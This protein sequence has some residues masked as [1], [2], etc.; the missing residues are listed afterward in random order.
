MLFDLDGTLVDP[1][2]GISGG[3]A[4]ALHEMGLP[5]PGESVLAA[6]V[7]PKLSDALLDLTDAAAVQLPEL[8]R[9]YRRW[10]ALKG[11]AMGR[12]YPGVREVLKDLQDRGIALGVATQKPQALAG[13]VL[14]AHGLAGYFSEVFGSADDET[15]RPSDPGYR[16]GKSEII[17]SAA[18]A[19][20]GPGQP[21]MVGDRAQDVLGA[22]A[23]GL[24]CI[25]VKWGFSLRGELE[26]AGAA[27]IVVD[28]P[29]LL[30]ELNRRL[31]R[32]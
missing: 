15:L 3:I 28:A 17:A 7:G 5:V 31:A 11:I 22:R 20:S 13:T 8:I 24:D 18:R 19:M 27:V 30:T 1:A 23:N 25:G 16:S 2:G 21:V 29:A 26:T 10:Y 9:R 4:H 32:I 6:M 14:R 12:V